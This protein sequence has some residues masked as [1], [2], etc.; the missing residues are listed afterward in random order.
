MG[1]AAGEG[2]PS[3]HDTLPRAGP[4]PH[5]VVPAARAS[6]RAIGKKPLPATP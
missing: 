2:K 6:S 1:G 4:I 5:L 3:A